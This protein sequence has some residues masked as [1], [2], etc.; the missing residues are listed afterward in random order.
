MPALENREQ[1]ERQIIAELEPVFEAE[2]R[3]ALASPSS[4]PYAEFQADLTRVMQREL[5]DVFLSAGTVLLIGNA[6]VV[7][8]GAFEQAAQS[9]ANQFAP[10]LAKDVVDTSKRLADGILLDARGD[11]QALREGLATVFMADARLE[12]IAITECTRAISAGENSAVFFYHLDRERPRLVPVWRTAE[13]VDVC[14]HCYPFDRHSREVWGDRFPL[15]PPM[16]PRCRCWLQ[17]IPAA[18]LARRAA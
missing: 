4:I 17:W 16:H 7:T 2:Y 10:E 6:V 5:T 3:R 1:I 12:N 15:G 9:W 14:E 18:E 8:A 11:R 13:D